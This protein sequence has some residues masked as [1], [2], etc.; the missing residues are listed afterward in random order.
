MKLQGALIVS[1]A[2]IASRAKICTLAN[3]ALIGFS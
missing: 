2:I 3:D 1:L